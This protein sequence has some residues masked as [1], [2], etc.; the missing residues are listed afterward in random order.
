M[1]IFGLT[2]KILFIPIFEKYHCWRKIN[3][4]AFF[5]CLVWFYVWL[6]WGFLGGGGDRFLGCFLLLSVLFYK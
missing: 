6:V 5:V 3:S 1:G 2:F 4:L